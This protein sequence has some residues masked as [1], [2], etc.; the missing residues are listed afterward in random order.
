MRADEA[1]KLALELAGPEEI[2]ADSGVLVPGEL[3]KKVLFAIDVGVGELLLA[4]ELGATGVIALDVVG[5]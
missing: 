2:P 4:R 5:R 3:G 1:L